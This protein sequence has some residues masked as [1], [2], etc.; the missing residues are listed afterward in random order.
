MESGG[1][2]AVQYVLWMGFLQLVA[3]ATRRQRFRLLTFGGKSRLGNPR[4]RHDSEKMYEL[5]GRARLY[6]QRVLFWG[7]LC[8]IE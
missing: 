7:T 4:L 6:H 3:L 8:N 2:S 1:T 5:T